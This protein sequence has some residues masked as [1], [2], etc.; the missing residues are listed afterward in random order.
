[1]TYYRM[2]KENP[3]VYENL[4]PQRIRPLLDAGM[5]NVLKDRA[6][7]GSRVILFRPGIDELSD[8]NVVSWKVSAEHI[9]VI[10]LYTWYIDCTGQFSNWCDIYKV[11]IVEIGQTVTVISQIHGHLYYYY[12]CTST[13]RALLANIL[14]PS[15]PRTDTH[16]HA[17]TNTH[18]RTHAHTHTHTNT[19]SLSV[20]FFFIGFFEMCALFFFKE[21]V[22]Q[23]KSRYVW[24]AA[25]FFSGMCWSEA[26]KKYWN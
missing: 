15:V 23:N 6:P 7:D 21:L 9:I 3:D 11:A 24:L 17:H 22:K 12:Y 14:L 16:T 26:D 19:L 2:R 18:S 25:D 5:A 10:K 8:S 1:M 13:T 20:C 4:T